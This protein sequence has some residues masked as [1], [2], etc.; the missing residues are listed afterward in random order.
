MK[1]AV[2]ITLGVLA[3]LLGAG[4]G[5]Y[6]WQR[7]A[8][9]VP[10]AVA[11]PPA[12]APQAVP[13]SAPAASEPRIRHPIEAPA[14]PTPAGPRDVATVLTDLVGKKAALSMLQLDDFPRRFVATV[15]NL[16]GARAPARLWP[17]V[18]AAGRFGVERRDDV[19]SIAA[20]N[21]DRYAAFLTFVDSV[22]PRRAASV[23]RT[24]YPEFQQA[25]E[26][27][28]YPGRYFNDRLVEVI[29]LLLATPELAVA[30]RVH[31]PPINGPVRPE[32]PWVLYEFDDP[33][34]D[35]L[36]SG[37][38]M[39]L[40]MGPAAERRMKARLLEFRRLIASGKGAR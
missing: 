31:L 25:Y 39:L 34:L 24:L 40:R 9:A 5:W 18:P 30:P 22:E 19:E 17:V 7:Q 6:W 21:A 20:G 2:V 28:G 3:L 16:G 38:K 32:R 15:D 1:K 14:D 12:I 27:L 13:P 33:A 35:R 8:R 29:D 37:Q 11:P 23:Y 26:E 10:V 36:A 4:A